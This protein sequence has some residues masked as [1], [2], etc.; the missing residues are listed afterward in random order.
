[1]L[2]DRVLSG[3]YGIGTSAKLPPVILERLWI[4]VKDPNIGT[5]TNGHVCGMGTDH[6]TAENDDFGGWDSGHTTQ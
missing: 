2:F 1:M 4:A 3:K 5:H 6:S